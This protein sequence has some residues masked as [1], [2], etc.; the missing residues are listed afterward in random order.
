MLPLGREAVMKSS[1]GCFRRIVGA[2][3]TTA[4]QPSGSK[5]PR[6]MNLGDVEMQNA[7]PKVGVFV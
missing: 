1:N 6:H 4:A 5:L 7:N 2:D 3:F